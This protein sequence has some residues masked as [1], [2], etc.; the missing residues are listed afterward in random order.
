MF[1]IGQNPEFLGLPTTVSQEEDFMLPFIK[2]NLADANIDYNNGI[3]GTYIFTQ[4]NCEILQPPHL[5]YPIE[6]IVDK[7]KNWT[8]RTTKLALDNALPCY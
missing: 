6:T 5:D 3:M 1:F 7:K 4:D 2:E 8:L